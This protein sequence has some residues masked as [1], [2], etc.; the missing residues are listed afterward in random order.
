MCSLLKVIVCCLHLCSA[1]TT[2]FTRNV[3]HTQAVSLVASM[4]CGEP[5]S[6]RLIK[7]APFVCATWLQKSLV[8]YIFNDLW[9]FPDN[10]AGKESACNAGDPGSLPGLGRSLGEGKGHP[11]QYYGL[12]NSMDC[13]GASPPPP[14][15]ATHVWLHRLVSCVE[16][17]AYHVEFGRY[18]VKSVYP[19]CC[20]KV[21][22]QPLETPQHTSFNST[23]IKRTTP[24]HESSGS[25]WVCCTQTFP[26][27][28]RP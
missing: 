16:W 24:A 12:E 4:P 9:G 6:L 18:R 19:E 7:I 11:L 25:G 10:S 27:W 15:L 14:T 26:W 3:R 20:A 5:R 17:S 13:L 28:W 23:V 1:Q 8:N 22:C 2:C 21:S